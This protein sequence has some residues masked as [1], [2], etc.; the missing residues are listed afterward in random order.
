MR[1]LRNVRNL[2]YRVSSNPA[3]PPV[4][5][6]SGSLGGLTPIKVGGGQDARL[7]IA[8]D[9]LEEALMRVSR[10][11]FPLLLALAAFWSPAATA[12]STFEVNI[13]RP[14]MDYRTFDIQGGPR[15]CQNACFNSGRCVAWT[16]VRPGYQG[17]YARCW[18]KTDV[19]PGIPSACCVSGIRN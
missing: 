7:A 8:P 15:A 6:R 9:V 10:A 16:Y 17:P 11:A 4:E 1:Q 5:R 2:S 19:P 13:D 3:P 18:L 14:G 12:Q